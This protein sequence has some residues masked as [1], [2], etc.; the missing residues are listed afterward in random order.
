LGIHHCNGNHC[1]QSGW[2]LPYSGERSFGAFQQH[3]AFVDQIRFGGNFDPWSEHGIVMSKKF[4]G[5]KSVTEAISIN[6]SAVLS[7]IEI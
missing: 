1:E 3:F 4:P 6:P 7:H 2:G 5:A